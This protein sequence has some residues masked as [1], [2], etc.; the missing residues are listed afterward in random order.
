MAVPSVLILD[1]LVQLGAGLALLVWPGESRNFLFGPADPDPPAAS[2]HTAPHRGQGSPAPSAQADIGLR[3]AGATLIA[4][5]AFVIAV[6]RVQSA[7]NRS[8]DITCVWVGTVP[9]AQPK[10][11][12]H[13]SLGL[14]LSIH[15]CTPSFFGQL[16]R[17]GCWPAGRRPRKLR[18]RRRSGSC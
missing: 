18:R 12:S 15:V 5:A 7:A 9:R 3:F 1:G 2:N 14:I 13:P 17:S 11:V 4:V 16:Q 8:A 6:G 10:Q